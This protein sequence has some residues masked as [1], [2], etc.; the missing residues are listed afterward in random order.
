MT[1]L[2]SLPIKFSLYAIDDG[3]T[4]QSANLLKTY[5]EQYPEIVVYSKANEGH[6]KAVMYGYHQAIG[7]GADWVFQC[8]SD[9]QFV[10]SDFLKLWERRQKSSFI[11][12]VRQDRQDP[13]AR[14]IIS[15]LLR[16]LSQFFFQSDATDINIPFRLM[17]SSLLAAL[18]KE[19]PASC[20]TPNIQLTLLANALHIDPLNI[21]ISHRKRQGGVPSLNFKELCRICSQSLIDLLLLRIFI[22][23]KAK[24]LK[25]I[26]P[27]ESYEES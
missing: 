17:R 16:S 5:Q 12:G 20:L 25:N 6:G 8:D 9:A 21:E 23:S 7:A 13:L 1:T 19:I 27:K 3:S 24:R 14:K 4:D 15:W 2:R 22:S 26:L 18:I 10:A 11:L